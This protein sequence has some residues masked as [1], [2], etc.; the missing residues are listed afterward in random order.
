MTAGSSRL[1]CAGWSIWAQAARIA[2]CPFGVYWQLSSYSSSP[3]NTSVTTLVACT[4][5]P[6]TFAAGY[7]SAGS[8]A[9]EVIVLVSVRSNALP[10]TASKAPF[11][12]AMFDEVTGIGRFGKRVTMIRSYSPTPIAACDAW[13]ALPLTR[14]VGASRSARSFSGYWK[15]IRIPWAANVLTPAVAVDGATVTLLIALLEE[16]DEEDPQPTSTTATDAIVTL[17]EAES[18]PRHTGTTPL[19][20]H[21]RSTLL[22]AAISSPRQIVARVSRGSITSSIM[23]LPAAT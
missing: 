5:R 7:S 1:I 22:S 21:G 15:W 13:P 18:H 11:N 23:S 2:L 8:P 14:L 4:G 6:T 9:T 12:F 19:R 16:L 17:P 3:R 20:F 10:I